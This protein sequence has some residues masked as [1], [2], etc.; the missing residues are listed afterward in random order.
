MTRRQI[1]DI[2]NRVGTTPD[3]S[4]GLVSTIA[5][6]KYL[7]SIMPR[8]NRWPQPTVSKMVQFYGEAGENLINLDVTGLGIFYESAP[9][10]TIRCHEKVA[11][12]LLAVIRDI[13]AGDDAYILKQYAGCFNYRPMR[14]S[15]SLSKHAWGV[16]IDFAPAT[17]DL[18]ASWPQKA[19]MPFGVIEAFSRHGWTSAGAFWGVDAMH[20]EATR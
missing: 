2:Q 3:G 18:H 5:C 8:P 10:K 12:S 17:N 4:W 14:N 20:F 6:Q 11:I 19:S 9:V 16:A 1:I 13:A 7:R 15:L